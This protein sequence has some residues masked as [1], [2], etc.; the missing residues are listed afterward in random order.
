MT[1]SFPTDIV[2][3][4]WG[5]KYPTKYVN[6]LYH[7]LKTTTPNIT[8]HCL[9]DNPSGITEE[10][11]THPLP[12]LNVEGWWWKLSLFSDHYPHLPNDVLFID[13]DMLIV[14]DVTPYL[15]QYKT[16][17]LVCHQDFLW[18]DASSAIML[19]DRSRWEVVWKEYLD[20]RDSMCGESKGKW[21]GDQS[22]INYAVNKED[23]EF[24]PDGWTKSWKWTVAKEGLGDTKII[25]FHG[26]PN[27]HD[28][29]KDP[30]VSKFWSLS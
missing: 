6:V 1:S 7:R 5:D 22:V 28:L 25:A 10:V 9:T 21:W 12:K 17:K 23:L 26:T 8:L 24:F 18:K 11:I 14:T 13:L 19:G 29:P 2:C 4:K 27:P 15:Q 3:L 20:K 30:I 16:E